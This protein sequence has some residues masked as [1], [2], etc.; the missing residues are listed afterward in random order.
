MKGSI[1]VP[2]FIEAVSSEKADGP[3][4]ES[5]LFVHVLDTFGV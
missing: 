5:K 3:F 2:L 1:C 4:Q